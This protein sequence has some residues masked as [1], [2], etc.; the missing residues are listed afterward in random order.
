MNPGDD[1]QP[2]THGLGSRLLEQATAG[3]LLMWLWERFGEGKDREK[4]WEKAKNAD[5]HD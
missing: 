1:D 2:W 5:Q 3:V 4:V